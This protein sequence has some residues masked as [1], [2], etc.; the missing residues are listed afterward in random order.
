MPPYTPLNPTALQPT[1]DLHRSTN[2]LLE[3]VSP[4]RATAPSVA[5]SSPARPRLAAPLLRTG[6]QTSLSTA[7]T[8]D[9][10]FVNVPSTC[11]ASPALTANST[12]TPKSTT[13]SIPE[14]APLDMESLTQEKL[15]QLNQETSGPAAKA[16][17]RR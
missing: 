17:K 3:S 8:N 2:S 5:S 13:P 11:S 9:S 10:I 12:N 15:E 6:S 4:T 1:C 14:D 7:A 16:E